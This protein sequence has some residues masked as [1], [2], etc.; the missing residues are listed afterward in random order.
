MDHAGVSQRLDPLRVL[1]KSM[2][3]KP[4]S[5]QSSSLLTAHS[6]LAT[7]AVVEDLL[8]MH[9]TTLL[10][11]LS[12]LRINTHTPQLM[13][14]AKISQVRPSSQASRRFRDSLQPSWLLLSNLAQ[15]Q[16][17]L[18]QVALPSRCTNQESSPKCVEQQLI[19]LSF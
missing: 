14:N 11:M 2:M 12:P 8:S 3:E 16:L 19:T 18:M 7:M 10:R 17:V 4:G 5:F 6:P 9:S 13:V 1:S 15:Y